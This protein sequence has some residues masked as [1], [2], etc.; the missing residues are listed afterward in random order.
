MLLRFIS[1]NLYSFNEETEFNLFPS[2]RTTH[3]L[4]HKV[5]CG[6][7][8]ALRMSAIY[9]A[10]G[11]GK[12][13]LIKALTLMDL[14]VT[15]GNVE[16]LSNQHTDLAFR[17]SNEKNNPISLAIEF[18]KNEKIYYYTISF[19]SGIITNEELY[20]SLENNDVRIFSREIID[21]KQK[22]TFAEGFSENASNATFLE[23]LQD[24]ILRP[25]EV[26]LS[27]LASKYPNEFQDATSA[28]EWFIQNLMT[29][30]PGGR[31]GISAHLF[32]SNPQMLDLL[33]TLLPQ[34]RTGV[35][36]MKI[37]KGVVDENSHTLSDEWRKLIPI[38]KEN[39]GKAYPMYHTFDDRVTA[40][41][42]YE[43][44]KVIM[45]TLE[46]I[47]KLEDGSE[48]TMPIYSESDGTLRLIDYIPFIYS[49]IHEDRIYIIDEI[50]RSLHPILIKEIINKISSIN[51]AKGQ[52]I[53]TT[54]ESCL[55]DQKIL[56]SDEIWFAE[57]DG[58][59]STHLYPLSD[60]NIHSTA[61]IENGYLNGRYGGIPF[62]SNLRDL[63]W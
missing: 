15:D 33:N 34:M 19:V 63:N 39:P 17:F 46:P 56:R 29:V 41:A 22:I 14:I 52:L 20:Q 62:L 16:F 45:K 50:E 4:H 60:F 30:F 43:D 9:G 51:E 31:P 47:H 10:N 59:Q 6:H 54:H 24:R 55:L 32:D 1:K 37:W 38:L 49:I 53:F 18:Y 61:N 40:S 25:E 3:H 42:V 28:H 7:A 44:G 8:K 5:S 23:V 27:F 26:L 35:S 13:N 12:S 58:G 48:V 2:S 57:K 36:K 21:G 11:A